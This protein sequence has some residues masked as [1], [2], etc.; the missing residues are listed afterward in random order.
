V[1]GLIFTCGL[2]AVHCLGLGK[3]CDVKCV[4]KRYR[5]GEGGI[6]VG[7][8]LYVIVVKILYCKNHFGEV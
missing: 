1:K 7:S 2:H 6:V 5:E 4:V 3:L 8:V